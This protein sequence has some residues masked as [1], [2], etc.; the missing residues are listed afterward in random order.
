MVLDRSGCGMLRCGVVVCL[1]MMGATVCAQQ[2]KSPL[3]RIVQKDGRFALM[4][5]GAPYL[6]HRWAR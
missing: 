3:P 2:A 4:V 6:M 1:I 5:D